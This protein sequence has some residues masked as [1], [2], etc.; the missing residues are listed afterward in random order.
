MIVDGGWVDVAVELTTHSTK[1]FDWSTADFSG[2][3]IGQHTH[4]HIYFLPPL[5]P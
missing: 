2:C 4:T 5:T 3:F 1:L